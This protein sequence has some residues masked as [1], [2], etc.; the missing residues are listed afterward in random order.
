MRKSWMISLVLV[1]A[2]AV[3]GFSFAAW[4]EAINING[5]VNTGDI[6][7]IFTAAFTNDDGVVNDEQLDPGDDGTDPG[8]DKNVASKTAAISGDQKTVTCTINNGYPGYHADTFVTIKNDGS[9]PVTITGAVVDAPAEVTVTTDGIE[10][11]TLD[12]GASITGVVHQTVNDNAAETDT[13]NYTVT[14]T[15]AQWNTAQTPQ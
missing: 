5:T 12:A 4:T 6:D 9:V 3:A 13:Y 11:Q 14:I 10:G 1:L 8:Q 7:P 15:A 2:L